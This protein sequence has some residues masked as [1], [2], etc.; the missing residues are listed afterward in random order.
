MVHLIARPSLED[1]KLLWR[2]VLSKAVGAE[3]AGGNGNE[4]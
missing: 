2:K 1:R 3:R 4:G